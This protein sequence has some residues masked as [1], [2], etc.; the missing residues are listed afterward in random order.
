MRTFLDSISPNRHAEKITAPLFVAQGHNDPR[1][2][3]SEAEQ[4]VR[5]VRANGQEVWYL[6]ALDE[7]HGFQKKANRDLFEQAAVHFL[8]LHLLD[9]GG[10]EGSSEPG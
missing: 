8:S 6:D 7:G 3:V 10:P 4:I 5:D 9:G 2:P 1:V